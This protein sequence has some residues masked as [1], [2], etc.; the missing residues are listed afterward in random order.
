[1]YGRFLRLLTLSPSSRDTV[2]NMIRLAVEQADAGTMGPGGG[3]WTAAQHAFL[4]AALGLERAAPASMPPDEAAAAGERKSDEVMAEP[5]AS[6][7]SAVLQDTLPVKVEPSEGALP[8]IGD[9]APSSSLPKRRLSSASANSVAAKRV[10]TE[11]NAGAPSVGQ[12][13]AQWPVSGR[14]PPQE[15]TFVLWADALT[16]LL[17]CD[18]T[19]WYVFWPKDSVLAGYACCSH[20]EEDSDARYDAMMDKGYPTVGRCQSLGRVIS[21]TDDARTAA[22]AAR[23]AA[24]RE[25][26]DWW[27]EF[28]AQRDMP[29]PDEPGVCVKLQGEDIWWI[30]DFQPA[31]EDAANAMTD[32]CHYLVCPKVG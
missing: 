2:D 18:G 3:E 8:Y 31:D 26:G 20:L 25:I 29:A 32:M 10:K 13:T 7:G 17:A 16:D 5:I 23:F 12:S 11:D 19:N 22:L 21:R 24:A 15:E 14:T 27:F 30:V 4:K 1:V 28:R 6:T 9:P